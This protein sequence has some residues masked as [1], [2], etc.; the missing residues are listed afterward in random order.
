MRELPVE[1]KIGPTKEPPAIPAPKRE[2][3]GRAY[4]RI[5]AA[6]LT[7]NSPFDITFFRIHCSFVDHPAPI[8]GNWA[9]VSG[10]MEFV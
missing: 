2:L 6:I 8:I 4:L 3:P 7:T 10:R 9:E 5:E 1:L